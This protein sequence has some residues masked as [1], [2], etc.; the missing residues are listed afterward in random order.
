MKHHTLHHCSSIATKF[1]DLATWI[2][3]HGVTP[4]HIEFEWTCMNLIVH[5]DNSIFLE[6]FPH[7]TPTV[8]SIGVTW[9]VQ[10]SGL[11]F[12]SFSTHSINKNKQYNT[13]IH[14]HTNLR[15]SA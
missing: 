4:W 9:R 2:E 10:E 3:Q 14:P 5:L 15:D 13:T 11:I 1:R 7:A 8:D 12:Q 6:L